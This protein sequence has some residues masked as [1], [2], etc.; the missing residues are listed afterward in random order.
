M[1]DYLRGGD[2]FTRLNKEVSHLIL[3]S[4]RVVLKN[5]CSLQ[6]MFT[7]EDAKFYLAEI[8]L[9]LDHLHSIGII[10]RDLSE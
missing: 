9:A 1:L 10:Y 8:A 6:I 3:V 5:V 4:K 7:E 2:L